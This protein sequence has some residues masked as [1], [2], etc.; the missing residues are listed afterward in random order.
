MPR[1]LPVLFVTAFLSLLASLPARADLRACNQ[2]SVQLSFAVGYGK[3][4][5]WTSEGWWTMAPGDCMTILQGDLKY[6]Y[7]YT[8]ATY[9]GGVLPTRDI[10]FCTSSKVF[11]I[12]GDENCE[13]RGYDNSTF[14]QID[15]GDA[16]SYTINLSASGNL[17]APG[18]D[19]APP[20]K[21]AEIRA[22]LQ[23]LWQDSDD[24]AFET[25]VQGNRIEDRFAGLAG[26][27]A[28]WRVAAT[29]PGANGAG[30]VMLVTY[31]DSTDNTLCWVL[32]GLNA[33]ELLFRAIGGTG[34]VYMTK[35]N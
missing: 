9:D 7:Y 28:T 23:G 16:K 15:T 29:C 14:A 1:F 13:Q 35:Q 12:V 6:R 19:T 26:A 22:N 30:P 21:Y 8:R 20:D 34:D 3:T 17:S 25:F 32:K 18:T 2:T 4:G 5:N 33:S 27:T 11:T 31:D 24:D 10:R